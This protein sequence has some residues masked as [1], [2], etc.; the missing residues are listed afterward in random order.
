MSAGVLTGIGCRVLRGL[1]S[2]ANGCVPAGPPVRVSVRVSGTV[3]L[4]GGQWALVQIQSFRPIS[5]GAHRKLRWAPL[6]L[7]VVRSSVD[8]GSGKSPIARVQVGEHLT[9][10]HSTLRIR[11]SRLKIQTVP[12]VPLPEILTEPDKPVEA[13]VV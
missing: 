1:L 11:P 8:N 13:V 7:H 10:D 12:L 3:P 9:I 2:T 6:L 5:R 4:I